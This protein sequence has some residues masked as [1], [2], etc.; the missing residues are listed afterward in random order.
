MT[1]SPGVVTVLM[2]P[3]EDWNGRKGFSVT[4]KQAMSHKQNKP[5]S[6]MEVQYKP[7][8]DGHRFSMLCT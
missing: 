3:G 7:D 8:A 4:A 1:E 6:T 5:L 2:N